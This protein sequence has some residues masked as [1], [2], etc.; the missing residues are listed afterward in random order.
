MSTF[1]R[2]PST[3]YACRNR[4]LY[5]STERIYYALALLEDYYFYHGSMK[6]SLIFTIFFVAIQQRDIK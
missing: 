5:H 4:R 2:A 3:T 1:I 6:F